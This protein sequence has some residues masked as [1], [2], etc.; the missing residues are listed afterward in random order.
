MHHNPKFG[1]CCMIQ[2]L[3]LFDAKFVMVTFT[4]AKRLIFDSGYVSV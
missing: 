2:V 4:H 1:F 3:A